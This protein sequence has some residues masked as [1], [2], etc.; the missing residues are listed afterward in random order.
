MLLQWDYHEIN[1]GINHQPVHDFSMTKNKHPATA[2]F[3]ALP[4]GGQTPKGW[5]P[6]IAGWWL[7]NPSEKW[8]TES[9]LGWWH[10]PF[11]IYEKRKNVPNHQRIVWFIT[12]WTGRSNHKPSRGFVIEHIRNLV[13]ANIATRKKKSRL[14]KLGGTTTWISDWD[15]IAG[16]EN[17]E[18][19]GFQRPTKNPTRWWSVRVKDHITM[20]NHHAING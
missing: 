12:W 5:L 17:L 18:L 15:I 6:Q 2:C 7:T 13:I 19:P 3:Q 20:E 1:H 8:W 11:P 9:Q 14:T 10:I 16:C 4:K